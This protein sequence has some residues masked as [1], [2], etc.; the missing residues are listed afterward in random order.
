MSGCGQQLNLPDKRTGASKKRGLSGGRYQ[1]GLAVSSHRFA[2][3][4]LFVFSLAVCL[5]LAISVHI[6]AYLCMKIITVHIWLYRCISGHFC[7]YLI[8]SEACQRLL[9]R[10]VA[11]RCHLRFA[12][13]CCLLS[14]FH[15]SSSFRS[16]GCSA[17]NTIMGL[18]CVW[19]CVRLCL[20]VCVCVSVS[21]SVFVF[22]SVSVSA[23]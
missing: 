12:T 17:R 4:I 18:A 15:T 11:C 10:T 2:R 22:E 9:Q 1:L 19:V 3:L 14:S 16:L 13:T 23:V 6:L 20:C 7:A 8:I 5:S 21:V